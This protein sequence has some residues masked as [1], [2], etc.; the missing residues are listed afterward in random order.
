MNSPMTKAILILVLGPLLIACSDGS[1]NKVDQGWSDSDLISLTVTEAMEALGSGELTSERYVEALITRIEANEPA[2]NA[3]IYFDADSLRADAVAA[4]AVRASGALVGPL[5]GLPIII[6][7]SIDVAGM[8]TTAGTPGLA[9]NMPAVSAPSVQRLVA[10]GAI[11]VGKANLHELSAG[12]TTNNAVTGATHNP[13]DLSRTAG[14]SSGGNAAALAA[15]Y[16]PAALGEDTAGSA[17]IPCA[18]TGCVGFRPTTGRYPSAG[19]FPLA[20]SSDTVAPMARTVEDVAL[21]DSILVGA[22]VAPFAAREVRGMRIG[23]PRRWFYDNL[24]PE[25]ELAMSRTLRQLT[26]AGAVLVEADVPLIDENVLAG[27]SAF[28]GYEW[29]D[30]V[31]NYLA[32]GGSGITLEDIFYQITSPDV[33]AEFLSGAKHPVTP[34]IYQQMQEFRGD[35]QYY[36]MSYFA[37]VGVEAIIYPTVAIPAPPLGNDFF[38]EVNGQELPIAVIG[39]NVNVMPF[40]GAPAINVGI[41]QTDAGLPMGMEIAGP[42]GADSQLLEI[43]AGIVEVV[44]PNVRPPPILPEPSH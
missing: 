44:G 27:L 4:D 41:G 18:F 43:A 34:E 23:V 7:D 17:R 12:F 8:F 35:V 30:A 25:V 16:A 20:P 3:F 40:I 31:M 33:L 5:H 36:Y 10:A 21:L 15:R 39:H 19:V 37:T 26:D 13:Y 9:G 1:D 11:I 29:A 32:L 38:V 14:G 24:N 42:I 6:K 2:L 22:P 28:I